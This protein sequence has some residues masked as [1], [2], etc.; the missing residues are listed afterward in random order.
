MRLELE[1]QW[2]ERYRFEWHKP[3]RRWVDRH[4]FERHVSDRRW[5]VRHGAALRWKRR[6]DME[7]GRCMHHRCA[8]LG[9]DGNLHGSHLVLD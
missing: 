9:H 3:Y 7:S 2:V 1:W 8:H 5:Y 6:R 4:R